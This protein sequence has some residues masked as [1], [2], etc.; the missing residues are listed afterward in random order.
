MKLARK[1]MVAFLE[2]IETT[3]IVIE[4]YGGSHH[5]AP[6]PQSFGHMV[7]L[8]PPQLAKPSYV[9]HGKND[10][11]DA[12]ALCEAMSRPTMCFV[13]VNTAEQQAALMLVGVRVRL[14]RKRT[15]LANTICAYAAE[16]DVTVAKGM[17]HLTT[18]L[19]R[20][21]ASE[22]LPALVRE[23]FAIKANEYARPQ[24][25]IEA[26]DAKLMAWH[27]ADGRSRRLA[28]TPAVGPIGGFCYP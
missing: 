27:R 26:V 19:E 6:L 12:E 5:W 2:K 1:T 17:A 3:A 9:K 28:K 7:R 16:F 14:I 11:A 8:I 10:P 4:A 24:E 20:I 21:S 23:L 13:P 25:E 22:N 15:Q 18:V